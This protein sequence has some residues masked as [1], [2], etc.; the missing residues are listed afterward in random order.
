MNTINTE[1]M[2][3]RERHVLDI[4]LERGDDYRRRDLIPAVA[5]AHPRRLVVR[6]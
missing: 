1:K 5:F 2:G 4:G 6:I 3:G